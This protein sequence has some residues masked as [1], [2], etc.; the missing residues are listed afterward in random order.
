M[1]TDFIDLLR[2]DHAAIELE[3][4]WVLDPR[5]TIAA[6]R[7]HMDEV[8]LGLTAHAEAQD[9]VLGPFEQIEPL[10]NLVRD[11]RTAHRHQQRALSLLVCTRPAAP[12]FRERAEDLLALVR[13]HDAEQNEHLLPALREYA[14]GTEYSLL[15]GQFATERLRQ[16][17]MLQPSAPVFAPFILARA[18][19]AS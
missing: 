3:L 1:T 10:A 7:A 6:L 19:R 5:S 17:A 15:A 12:T 14:P 2:R 4:T 13:E 11:A 8:R 18:G 9:I 16:L